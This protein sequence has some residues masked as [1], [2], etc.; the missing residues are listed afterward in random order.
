MWAVKWSSVKLGNRV[1][2]K[3][4]TLIQ[5]TPTSLECNARHCRAAQRSTTHT[6]H[7]CWELLPE[8]QFLSVVAPVCVVEILTF[9]WCFCIYKIFRKTIVITLDFNRCF[10]HMNS[11]SIFK[12]L[13]HLFDTCLGIFVVVVL[14]LCL[15]S[16]S[17]LSKCTVRPSRVR[18]HLS[19]SFSSFFLFL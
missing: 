16:L 19:H 1:P 7:I 12:S 2:I 6:L 4:V 15:G 9:F 13:C 3:C 11:W 14:I 17:S 10:S 8:V 5:E 18:N